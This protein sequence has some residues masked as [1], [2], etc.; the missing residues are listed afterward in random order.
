MPWG[1]FSRMSDADLEALWAFFNSLDPVEN[2]VGPTA[3]RDTAT[4]R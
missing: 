4:A 1:S 3:F 2:D